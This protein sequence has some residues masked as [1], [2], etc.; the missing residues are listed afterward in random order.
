[1]KRS[2]I[3]LS[4]TASDQHNSK[5][6]YH[7]AALRIDREQLPKYIFFSPNEDF[8]SPK[9]FNLDQELE[10]V[11]ANLR[12][13]CK[14]A[15]I[16]APDH[17]TVARVNQ[18]LPLD[19]QSQE[20]IVITDLIVLF[21][22]ILSKL[23]LNELREKL[24]IKPKQY[25][26]SARKE[27][28]LTWDIL[29]KCWEKGLSCD[30]S[31][32]TKLQEYTEGLAVYPFLQEIV[33]E[34]SKK[35]PDRAISTQ[36]YPQEFEDSI[37]IQ[38]S[39]AQEQP[40]SYSSDWV[41]ACFQKGG[42]L[43]QKLPGYE[44]RSIQVSMAKEII[45]GFEQSVNI[46]IEAGTGTGKSIAYLIPAL[47]WARKNKKRII[48]ATHT[49]TLQ[50][51]LYAKDLPLLQKV[52][53]FAFKAALLKGKGNYLCLKSLSQERLSRD[54]LTRYEKLALAWI[55]SWTRETKS[56]DLGELPYSS[57]YSSIWKR[58]GADNPYCLPQDCPFAKQCYLLRARKTAEDADLVIVNHSLLFADIKTN[59]NTLPDYS[60]LIIDEAHNICQTALKQLGF[61][62][63]LEQ[64]QRLLANICEG[65]SSLLAY[66]KKSQPVWSEGFPSI[67]W[68]DFNS[69]LEKMPGDCG[70]IIIQARELFD[71]GKS[72]L[73]GRSSL[74]LDISK[75]GQQVYS[76]FLVCIENLGLR[77]RELV[78]TLDRINACLSIESRQLES[79]KLEILRLK[80]EILLIIEGLA[81]ISAEEENRVTYLEL[82]NTVYLKNTVVDIAGILQEKIY[83]KTN[84]T[85]LTSA[86][87]SVSDSFSYF[88][89]DIGLKHYHSIKL[90][91]PFAY[92][93]QMLFCVVNDLPVN[94]GPE[95]ELAVNTA[96]FL[97]LIAE[98]MQGRTLVLFTSHRYLRLVR[99]EL[100]SNLQAGK[101]KVLAQGIDGSRE[102]LLRDFL[103]DQN[104]VLLGAS[105][106]WEGIDIPG[107]ALKCVVIPRLPFW[108]PDS[109]ILEAKANLLQTQ[110]LN[111]FNELHLPEAIIR[112]KQGFGRLI[113][114]KDDKGVVI[115]LDDRVLYKQYG[116][117]FLKSLPIKSY[118]QGNSANVVKQVLNWV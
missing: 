6:Q 70:N 99:A 60:E 51:Q 55:Y 113:R 87:L 14:D 15:L 97:K 31:F 9:P 109:P 59:H 62:I 19:L 47:W 58:Y 1:L 42:I 68:S 103:K 91:S 25:L 74:R 43:S 3:I 11:L 86:T 63:S 107:D 34:I 83:E 7:F 8:G 37:F 49:I 79:T 89:R 96:S 56:G 38:P 40:I 41:I 75:T 61:E 26:S 57:E 92:H 81:G 5:E 72:M 110:G 106:F 84:C 35:Y 73:A 66:L 85:V 102:E 20:V 53:P 46:V 94:S 39:E 32:L 95:A 82:S 23:S 93:K 117:S 88:A 45:R 112:F 78:H 80:N 24:G 101:L 50:E 116:R 18:T 69:Y 29:K 111:A 104:T 48:V 54:G 105:S 90:D 65:R 2:V 76:V 115:L 17:S 22:P 52:L 44:D 108:P 98:A 28:R 114:T 77:L 21:F 10:V 100:I 33:K 67:N 64:L 36:G 12:D 16:F 27:V 4:L 30:L 118:F 71:L 13:Y